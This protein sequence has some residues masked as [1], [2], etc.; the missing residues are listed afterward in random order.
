MGRGLCYQ[1]SRTPGIVC[2]GLADTQLDRT[3][4]AAQVTGRPVWTVETPEEA[5]RAVEAQAVFACTDGMLLASTPS[6]DVVIEASSAIEAGGRFAERALLGQKHVVLMN[7]EVDLSFGPYLAALAK[8]RGV[9]FT[10]TDGDQHGVIK[11]LWDEVTLW[12]IE[13]VLAGNI[14]GFLDRYAT[15]TT[16]IPEADK[17]NL[18]YRM[19]TAFTDGTKLA[20]E[21]ALLANG[22]GLQADVPGMHGPKAAH[23]REALSLFDLEAHRAKGGTVDYLLGAEPGGGVFVIGYCNNR[24]QQRMLAY[25]KMGDGPYYL[26]YRPY[27]LCHIEAMRTVAEACLDGVA[28]LTPDHGFRANVIAY[29]KRDL[30]EG[31]RLDGVG[32]Y[33]V[34]GLLENVPNPDPDPGLPICLSH[35]AVLRRGLEKDDRIALADVDLDEKGEAWR[36]YKR[37]LAAARSVDV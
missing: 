11:R 8:D 3:M 26:F 23:V 16:I 28:L 4:A 29:V 15:P 5:A 19:A 30:R 6:V 18:D 2:V 21:M 34:Y 31:E 20:V 27:H 9:V 25:Y 7:A 13:P 12:D 36:L 32:G 14:K 35:G 33:A 1:A 22:L 37:A 10:S 17:R 24:Y